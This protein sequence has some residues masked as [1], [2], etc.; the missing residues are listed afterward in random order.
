MQ[1]LF[2]AALGITSPWYV[3]KIDFDVVNKSLRIDVDFEAGSTFKDESEG[4]NGKAY[5]AYDTIKK[6]WRHL[7]FFEHECYLTARVPRVKR[8]DGRVRMIPP[9]W[10]G[11]VSGFTLLFEAL[12]IQLCKAMPVHNVSQLTQ[13]SDYLIWRI[14]DVYTEGAKF[15]EDLSGIE[16][17]GMDV[18]QSH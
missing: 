3:K 7:N 15:D 9:P 17:I 12:I 2:E 4:A 13:A 14:L 18:G 6:E 8:D 5:K 11:V 16:S 10:S 1:K